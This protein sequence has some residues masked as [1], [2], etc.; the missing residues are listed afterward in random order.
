MC[1]PPRAMI[2]VVVVGQLEIPKE[3]QAR[4]RELRLDAKRFDDW[5]GGTPLFTGE[6]PGKHRSVGDVL[7]TAEA[8]TGTPDF[9]EI[10][11][12]R[13]NGLFTPE[14]TDA[15]HQ[16]LATALRLAGEVGAQGQ[17]AFVVPSESLAFVVNIGE[18]E[19]DHHHDHDHGDDC[20]HDHD[21]DHHHHEAVGWVPAQDAFNLSPVTSLTFI[22]TMEYLQ[23]WQA[24]NAVTRAA[25]LAERANLGLLPLAEQPQHQ[26]VLDLVRAASPEILH[27]AMVAAEVADDSEAPLARRIPDAAALEKALAD[28]APN[29]RAAAIELLSLTDPDAAIARI[30]P[31]LT[32]PSTQVRRHAVRALGHVPTDAALERLL[33]IEPSRSDDPYFLEVLTSAGLASAAP[34]ADALVRAL[35]DEPELARDTWKSLDRVNDAGRRAELTER[36]NQRLGLVGKR[37]G[38]AAARD[39]LAIHDHHP[40]EEVRLAA[41]NALVHTPGPDVEARAHEIMATLNGMGRAL[42]DDDGRRRKILGVENENYSLG[43]IRVQDI[44]VDALQTLVDERFANPETSQNE[45]PPISQ[46]LELMTEHPELRAGGYLIPPTRPDYRVSLD[47]LYLP[48]LE[49]VDDEERR[50]EL[51]GIFEELA[52]TATNTDPEGNALRCWWT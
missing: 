26:A 8:L 20:D 13:V 49:A 47:S 34:N 46:F 17:I 31:F 7:A 48:D 14:T 18:V 32:D 9:F 21:H 25:Y 27:M 12:E 23:T 33:A 51:E 16:D 11:G 37:L 41:A 29:A 30:E 50:E 40:A 45:A 10:D 15:L 19:H 43:L 35:L 39:L 24:D 4:W 36:A 22:R 38:E 2:L 42:N 5:P 52:E 28:A 6:S 44:D 3:N 1:C